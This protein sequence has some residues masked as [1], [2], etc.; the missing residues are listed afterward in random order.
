MMLCK[1]VDLK[2]LISG[3]ESSHEFQQSAQHVEQCQAC[4]A[5]LDQLSSQGL[6]WW[7][8]A[9]SSWQEDA[10][11]SPVSLVQ[12]SSVVIA[13]DGMNHGDEHVATEKISLDFLDRPVHP[14]L[15]GR[16]GRYDVERVIGQ[17]GMG[18]VLKGYDTE[19]HR[20]VAIKVLAPHLA[21]YSSARRRFAREAQAAAAVVHP[22]VIPIFDV[23]SNAKFPYLVM[24]FVPGQSLQS[25]TDSY[26]PLSVTETLRIAQQTAAGLA[27]AHAQGLVHRDVKPANILLEDNVDRVLLSD[28][29]LA[30]AVDDASL[31]RTGVVAGTPYYMSPEQARGD[32][33]DARSDLFSLGSVIYF[34]LTGHPPF[35][36]SGAMAVLHRICNETPRAID[37]INSQVPVEVIQVV[38]R[39]LSKSPDQRFANATDVEKELARLL[40]LVQSGR[41]SL[42]SRSQICAL[43][44]P[45][46]QNIGHAIWN[47]LSQPAAILSMAFLACVIG[48]VLWFAVQPNSDAK[49]NS[50][51]AVETTQSTTNES[52]TNE[53]GSEPMTV[54]RLRELQQEYLMNIEED[55]QWRANASWLE[56]EARKLSPP[57]DYSQL[58][59]PDAFWQSMQRVEGQIQHERNRQ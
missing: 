17:G 14:E 53:L 59:T 16:L 34:M 39:L 58:L 24:Q 2:I 29:G 33:I 49:S 4:Q 38:D 30:R 8:E 36:A 11:P 7:Q 50:K 15:L 55:K 3:E 27:A 23:E 57:F 41:L 26:G 54:A 42:K 5:K 47:R 40:S 18:V 43:K 35:R 25:R 21:H 12:T 44:Y 37:Q 31:T 13:I 56:Y 6:D 1:Q 19:L 22:H 32:A 20:V 9:K 52:A 45:E 28:F 46:N 48:S 10:L 51:S